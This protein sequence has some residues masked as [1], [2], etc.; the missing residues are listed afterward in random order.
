MENNNIH[1][2]T[3]SNNITKKNFFVGKNAENRIKS[4]PRN[5]S[6]NFNK[7]VSSDNISNKFMKNESK[8]KLVDINNEKIKAQN[9]N[10]YNKESFNPLFKRKSLNK[11]LIINS[12]LD[13]NGILNLN[14]IEIIVKNQP[15]G[16]NENV[17]SSIN[18][19][20]SE[21]KLPKI[22]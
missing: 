4:D 10:N 12:N 6:I 14:K 17:I 18:Y 11:E 1:I 15:N 3:N 7:K 13:K 22:K 21:V 2:K 9:Y 16:A 20:L 5:D 8:N 19:N